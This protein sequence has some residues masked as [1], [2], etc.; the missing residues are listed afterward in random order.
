MIAEVG[1]E[2]HHASSYFSFQAL[3][4]FPLTQLTFHQDLA[5]SNPFCCASVNAIVM[6]SFVGLR[7]KKS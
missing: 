2:Q 7:V 6:N 1:I 4:K 5:Q 3:T